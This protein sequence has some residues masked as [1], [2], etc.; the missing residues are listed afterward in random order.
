M[1]IFDKL[2]QI[3]ELVR[4]GHTYDVLNQPNATFYI[5]LEENLLSGIFTM[6][7]EAGKPFPFSVRA[8]KNEA[9][10]ERC[11]VI[12]IKDAGGNSI[13]LIILIKEMYNPKVW[14]HAVI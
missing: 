13:P 8:A 10:L 14:V 11:V 9:G 1:T 12:T 2:R 4:K 3:S 7:I 6:W 5:C